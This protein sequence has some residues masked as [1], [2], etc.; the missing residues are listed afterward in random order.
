MTTTEYFEQLY[1]LMPSL[2]APVTEFTYMRNLC[3][4]GQTQIP[5]YLLSDIRNPEIRSILLVAGC[6]SG[7]T[8]M[9]LTYLAQKLLH[10]DRSLILAVPTTAIAAQAEKYDPKPVILT[11]ENKRSRFDFDYPEIYAAVYDKVVLPEGGMTTKIA[12]WLSRCVLVIDEAHDPETSWSYRP[13]AVAGMNAFAKAVGEYG[14]TVI[15]MTGTPRKLGGL[16]FDDVVICSRVD[17]LGKQVPA[18]NFHNL[19]LKQEA[20][21]NSSF[22][23]DLI[24]EIEEKITAHQRVILFYNDKKKAARICARV[25]RD[26]RG[27]RADLICSENKGYELMP[28]GRIYRNEH[29]RSIVETASLQD[30][31]LLVVTSVLNNGTSISNIA[32]LAAN[33]QL[34]LI[35]AIP[36]ANA[37]DFDMAQQFFARPRFSYDTAE[38][39]MACCPHQRMENETYLPVTHDIYSLHGSSIANQQALFY[40]DKTLP[41][42]AGLEKEMQ[43][44]RITN[45]QYQTDFESIVT[46]AVQKHDKRAFYQPQAAAKTIE[47][48]FGLPENTCRVSFVKDHAALAKLPAG[49]FV[50]DSW[51]RILSLVSTPG[52]EAAM[53][54]VSEQKDAVHAVKQFSLGTYSLESGAEVSGKTILDELMILAT[55]YSMRQSLTLIARMQKNG[56]HC[57]FIGKRQVNP[58]DYVIAHAF[59]LLSGYNSMQAADFVHRMQILY[60]GRRGAQEDPCYFNRSYNRE[61]V[62]YVVQ[63]SAIR[64]TLHQKKE[65]VLL[66]Y[67][68]TSNHNALMKE[69]IRDVT[70]GILKGSFADQCRYVMAHSCRMQDLQFA[71][72][73]S[74]FLN[75]DKKYAGSSS[76]MV[77]QYP[78]MEEAVYRVIRFLP[79]YIPEYIPAR[80]REKCDCG[81]YPLRFRFGKNVFLTRMHLRWIAYCLNNSLPR[82][83]H[84]VYRQLPAKNRLCVQLKESDILMYLR[85]FWCM[86]RVDGEFLIR[87]KRNSM[88]VRSTKTVIPFNEVTDF[89][90]LLGLDMKETEKTPT[91]YT[92]AFVCSPCHIGD[93]TTGD[94]DGYNFEQIGQESH[95]TGKEIDFLFSHNAVEHVVDLPKVARNERNLLSIACRQKSQ[96]LVYIRVLYPEFASDNVQKIIREHGVYGVDPLFQS[97]ANMII[98]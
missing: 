19:V 96:R 16:S 26:I 2:K 54:K 58:F 78:T 75:F 39:F 87:G 32:D 9:T 40:R 24:H 56:R 63:P 97:D 98:A 91:P 45:G 15:R 95:G 59:D 43:G 36:N 81:K 77:M 34:C 5:D 82:R 21:T 22:L 74:D 20:N 65:E 62:R 51:N 85:A 4:E 29:Y 27:T 88:H 41:S 1:T 84:P 3:H 37:C 33:E 31:N 80:D 68:C 6:G 76:A 18:C 92:V 86:D 49:S 64:P 57:V 11:A 61:P 52:F 35:Y 50:R 72:I 14:G 93:C 83:Q 94:G 8:H 10:E 17:I 66:S 28:E 71:R 67:A 79:E 12:G 44:I 13:A 53:Y 25:E 30:F 73:Q 23:G 90:S 55:T 47:E 60:E 42:V 38:V 46:L 48:A 69:F 89:C 7:K 70:R